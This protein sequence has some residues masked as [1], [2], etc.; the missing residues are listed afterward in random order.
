M[1]LVNDK[2]ISDDEN[3]EFEDFV[4][5]V[6]LPGSFI[7]GLSIPQN[8]LDQFSN[9]ASH[10]MV[11][12]PLIPA[13][14]NSLI[15]DDFID[16]SL[17]NTDF[18]P[19]YNISLSRNASNEV[20]NQDVDCATPDSVDTKCDDSD[21]LMPQDILRDFDLSP[22]PSKDVLNRS[23]NIKKVD[24]IFSYLEANNEDLINA[25]TAYRIP[26]CISKAILKQSISV[27]I[28]FDDKE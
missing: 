13:N 20:T 12:M 19:Q 24:K 27:A 7:S 9:L 17:D 16:T 11:K 2:F 25:M 18:L 5:Q 26:H 4:S 28:N 23:T 1:N 14:V 22:S 10:P 6:E 3:L 8:V 15:G 21:E